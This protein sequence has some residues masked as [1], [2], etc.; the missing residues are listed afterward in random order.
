MI[1]NKFT[2]T[3]KKKQS[4]VTNVAV[5]LATILAWLSGYFVMQIVYDSIVASIIFGTLWAVIV[6]CECRF[7]YISLKSDGKI[8]VSNDEIKSNALH[9]VAALIMA[10]L[11]ALPIELKIFESDIIAYAGDAHDLGLQIKTMGEIFATH[12]L[13]MISVALAVVV[14]FQIPIFAKMTSEN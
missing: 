11:V 9:I 13:S 3:R 12:W 2:M 7:S 1:N 5:A 8:E 4:I 10:L 6:F 14:I